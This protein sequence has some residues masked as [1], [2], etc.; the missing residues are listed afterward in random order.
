MHLLKAN[1]NGNPNVGLYGFA[2]D[3]YCLL[4]KEVN[5]KLVKQIEEVLKVPVHQIDIC[6]TSLIGAF[7][8]GNSNSLLVPSIAFD[9][10]LEQLKKLKIPFTV[11]DTKH[12]ALGNN[13]LCNDNGCLLSTDF[14]K[15]EV[16]AI[17]KVLVVP[18]ER[19][20]IADLRIVGACGT[21]NTKGCVLHRD[22]SDEDVKLIESLLK[23]RCETGTVNLA[24]PYIKSAIIANS[25]GFI[26]GDLSGGPEINHIDEVLGF[27]KG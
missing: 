1:F 22:A 2:T 7:L 26:I 11:I 15:E 8:A 10:E 25:N 5:K 12:T 6:G 23:V 18:T 19:G 20:N 24:N 14:K 3:S 17:Q 4:S 16:E 21:S 9:S 13:I 27:L